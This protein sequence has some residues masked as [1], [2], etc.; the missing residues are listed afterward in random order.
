MKGSYK[1]YNSDKNV[2]ESL[3]TYYKGSD[4]I[5]PLFKLENNTM[6]VSYDSGNT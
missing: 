1:V 6:Y 2:W 3:I 5:T 4:G